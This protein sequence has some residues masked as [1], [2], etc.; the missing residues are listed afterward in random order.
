MTR[1][2]NSRL[3]RQLR[4]FKLLNGVLYRDNHHPVG[5]KLVPVAPRAL[6]LKILEALHDDAA[7]GHLGFQKTYDRVRARFFFFGQ[8]SQTASPSSSPRVYLASI[9]NA[10]LLLPRD[11]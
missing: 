10:L 3:R 11:F 6:Q 4:K 5:D 9:G 1:P 2:P 8:A 7:A